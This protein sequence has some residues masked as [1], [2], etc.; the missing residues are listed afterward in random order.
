MTKE[1][2]I[3]QKIAETGNCDVVSRDACLYC[4]LAKLKKRPDGTGW[5][6]CYEAIVAPSYDNVIEKYKDAARE[7]L[8]D[9]AIE[10]AMSE[11]NEDEG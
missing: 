8:M 6:S 2:K 9:M 11:A 5:L 10:S 3:L 4:P 1:I 7:K